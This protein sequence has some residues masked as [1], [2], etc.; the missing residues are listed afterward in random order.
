MKH[1][2][3][4]MVPY[5]ECRVKNVLRDRALPFIVEHPSTHFNNVAPLPGI[6]H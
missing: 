5:S 4:D 1:I 2:N 3:E 6:N